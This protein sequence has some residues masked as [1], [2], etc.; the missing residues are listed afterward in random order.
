MV[1]TTLF[2]VAFVVVAALQGAACTGPLS[3]ENRS[4]PCVEGYQCCTL[5]NQCLSPGEMC[6]PFALT[7]DHA[8][9]RQGGK[10]TLTI[11]GPELGALTSVQLRNS[12]QLRDLMIPG[13][14][15]PSSAGV[16]ELVIPIPHGAPLGPYDLRFT[17]RRDTA[18]YQSA[19]VITVSPIVVARDGNDDGTGTTEQPFRTL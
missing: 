14:F 18:P 3:I 17:G 5:T 6:A 11:T 7:V 15:V 12:A 16:F 13:P 4:C 1:K 10:V 8:V 2:K 9:V 19:S